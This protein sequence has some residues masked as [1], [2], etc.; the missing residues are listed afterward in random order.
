ME[1]EERPTANRESSIGHVLEKWRSKRF[2]GQREAK[3]VKK[4][5]DQ[6]VGAKKEPGKKWK[7]G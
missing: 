7:V 2:E 4:K 1:E 6:G 3:R 5:E